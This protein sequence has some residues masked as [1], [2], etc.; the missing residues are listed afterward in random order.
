MRALAL[1]LLALAL[2]FGGL[3]RA[4]DAPDVR[5]IITRQLDAFAADD[6][7]AA[8]ALAA[9]VIQQKFGDAA[10]FL[11]MVKSAYPPVYRRR[12]FE[13]GQ[14]KRD[15]DEIEQDVVFVDEDND[16][17]MGAYKLARQP[18]DAWKITTCVLIRSTQSSL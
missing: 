12:S 13:F 16:V 3:A 10:T 8:F 4:D 2:A 7:K 11:A 17:W 14:Q 9:P 5:A 1:G 18:D 6:A 15:G